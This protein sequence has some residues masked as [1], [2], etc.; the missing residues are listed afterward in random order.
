MKPRIKENFLKNKYILLIFFFIII[1]FFQH[2]FFDLSLNGVNYGYHTPDKFFLLNDLKNSIIYQHSQPFLYSLY[3]GI[4][5]KIS[6]GDERIVENIFLFFNI[7]LSLGILIY[8]FKILEF[9]NLNLK[10]NFVIFVLF[11]LWPTILFYENLFSYHQILTFLFTQASFYIFKLFNY[12]KFKHELIV[13]VDI[14]LMSWIWS[15]MT[16]LLLITIFIFLQIFLKNFSI[17]KVFLFLF[18]TSFSLVPHIKNKIIFGTFS[19]SSWSGHNFST[20]FRTEW[21]DFCGH[22]LDNQK[23]YEKRYILEY[24]KK[25]EHSYL[26]GEQ[27]RFNNI[28]LIVKSKECFVKTLSKINAEPE[29]YFFTRLTAI[30]ATHGKFPFD[31]VPQPKNFDKIYNSKFINENY[32][33]S[34]QIILLLINIFIYVFII[35]NFLFLQ[36]DKKLKISILIVI[37]MYAYLF[38]VSFLFSCCEQERMLYHGYVKLIIFL[39]LMYK[40]FNSFWLRG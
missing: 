29:K 21:L 3:H 11:S 17:K 36:I 35:Y 8:F 10:L 15:A 2:S 19:P 40:K 20:T 5:L 26:V 6:L 27:S 18:I 24:D 9:F 1:R 14:I 30:I 25:F 34:R 39:G 22:P 12:K 33:F 28:G 31:F 32:K 23:R 4:L 38:S 37:L 16:P 13:Y 7:I